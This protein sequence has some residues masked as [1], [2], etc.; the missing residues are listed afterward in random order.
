MT[1]K[2]AQ[3]EITEYIEIF[4]NRQRTQERFGLSVAGRFHAAIPFE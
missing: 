1:R 2:Q 4:Y 3:K